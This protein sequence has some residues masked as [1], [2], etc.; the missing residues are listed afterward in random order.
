MNV[1]V[2]QL[3]VPT[4]VGVVVSEG[5]GVVSASCQDFNN[6]CGTRVN[7]RFNF[8]VREMAGITTIIKHLKEVIAF[9]L[10]QSM[11]RYTL[12]V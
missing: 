1:V 11:R 7:V 3:A 8:T 10:V 4:G 6:Q 12:P 5:A 9:K 2:Q